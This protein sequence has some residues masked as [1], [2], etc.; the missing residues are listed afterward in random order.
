MLYYIIFFVR[1][2]ALYRIS[3]LDGANWKYL[4]DLISLLVQNLSLT[5]T[6]EESNIRERINS[7][8]PL[9]DCKTSKDTLFQS[10]FLNYL[11]VKWSPNPRKNGNKDKTILII[12][13]TQNLPIIPSK[14]TWYK[15]M[16]CYI[17]WWDQAHQMEDI[18]PSEHKGWPH[19]TTH[20]R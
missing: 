1:S 9:K 15:F 17:M 11:E 19:R 6:S 2:R 7:A 18:L 16:P 4:L 12:K 20:L 5:K 10:S 14:C 3:R 13:K 8:L